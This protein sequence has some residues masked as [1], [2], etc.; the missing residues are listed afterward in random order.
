MPVYAY[1]CQ[2]CGEIFQKVE[3]MAEHDTGKR[4]PCPSCNSERVMQ[5]FAPF[6]AKT[7]KKS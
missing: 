6:F 4:P 2:D 3:H 5:V 1:R 7:Q